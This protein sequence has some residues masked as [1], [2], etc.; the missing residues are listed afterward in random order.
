MLDGG[1][2]A[3]PGTHGDLIERDGAYSRLVA[4]QLSGELDDS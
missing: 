2:V 3:E 4:T 1:C